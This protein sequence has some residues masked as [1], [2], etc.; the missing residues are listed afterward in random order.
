MIKRIK[1]KFN[2]LYIVSIFYMCLSIIAITI[3]NDFDKSLVYHGIGMILAGLGFI[4][5]KIEE[6]LRN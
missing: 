1:E 3:E 5:N 4:Y 6:D 2:I